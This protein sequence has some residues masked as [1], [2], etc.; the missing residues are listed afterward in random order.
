MHTRAARPA[1]LVP[2]LAVAVAVALSGCAPS[3]SSNR[4]TLSSATSASL[5]TVQTAALAIAQLKSGTSTNAVTI[6]ALGDMLKRA[7]DSRSQVSQ[8]DA[9][10]AA[11]DARRDR[12]TVGIDA[13]ITALTDGRQSIIGAS[14][15]KSQ[16]TVLAELAAA[17]KRLGALD[18]QLA[19]S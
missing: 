14:G 18:K 3:A 4:S 1:F 6:T 11:D 15:A 13:A 7:T 10:S 12:V 2:A 17:A 9:A 5:A 8:L 16:D 19:S